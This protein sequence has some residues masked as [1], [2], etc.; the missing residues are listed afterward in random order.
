MEYTQQQFFNDAEI[1][2]SAFYMTLT[3]PTF[4]GQTGVGA[5]NTYIMYFSQDDKLYGFKHTV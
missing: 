3:S 5:D 2:N 4:E 1:K